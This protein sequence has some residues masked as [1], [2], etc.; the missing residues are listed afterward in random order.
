MEFCSDKAA[1]LACSLAIALSISSG[2]RSIGGCSRSEGDVLVVET[3]AVVA[4]GP[5]LAT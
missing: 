2:E 5:L 4:G 1:S 3:A